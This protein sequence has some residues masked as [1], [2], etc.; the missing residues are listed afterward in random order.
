MPET[1]RTP[2]LGP[3]N[4]KEYEELIVTLYECPG[5]V[6]GI[7]DFT[8]ENDHLLSE[9]EWSLISELRDSLPTV[10]DIPTGM[11]PD[12]RGKRFDFISGHTV[13]LLTS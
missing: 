3:H 7:S 11:C 6:R 8:L 1:A 5:K 9:D 2:P 10:A 4:P 12:S 13:E